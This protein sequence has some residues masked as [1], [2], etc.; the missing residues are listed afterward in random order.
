MTACPCDVCNGLATPDDDE[1][2]A[3][4]RQADA[5]RRAEERADLRADD[6]ELRHYHDDNA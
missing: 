1:P 4:D 5:D 6:E 2:S 3:E